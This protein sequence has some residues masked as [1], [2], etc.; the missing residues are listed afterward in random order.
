MA[1]GSIV[2]CSNNQFATVV[3]MK[4]LLVVCA[5]VACVVAGVMEE[6]KDWLSWKKVSAESVLSVG[7]CN[8]LSSFSPSNKINVKTVNDM[9]RCLGCRTQAKA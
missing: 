7:W 9:R 8:C 3:T 1:V 5:L 6:D 4:T 2:T